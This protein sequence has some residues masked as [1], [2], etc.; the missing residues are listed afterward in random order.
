MLIRYSEL[1]SETWN[2]LLGAFEAALA[3]SGATVPDSSARH[4]PVLEN[5][6]RCSAQCWAE[7]QTYRRFSFPISGTSG[8]AR[9]AAIPMRITQNGAVLTA[10]R[11]C[12]PAQRHVGHQRSSGPGRNDQPQA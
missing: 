4:T 5:T 10:P 8:D 1:Q 9:A 11:R 6:H 2:G 3:H 7:Y 12:C